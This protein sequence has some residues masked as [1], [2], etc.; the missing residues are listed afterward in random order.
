MNILQHLPESKHGPVLVTLNPPF[1]PDPLKTL[2]RWTYTHPM[3]TAESVSSQPILPSIQ[4]KRHISY[5]GAWT[6]YGF[7]EDGFT[8]AMRLVTAPPFSVKPPFPVRP[9]HRGVENKDMVEET[10]SVVLGAMQMVL[11]GAEP[12]WKWV[13]ILAVVVL[14]LVG[15][16]AEALH[17]DPV[18]NEVER[19]RVCWEGSE[20][21]ESRKRR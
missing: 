12:V 20:S 13:V 18:V 5:A 10:L 19:L 16:L 9:A 3:M 21:E 8:S 17:L 1:P 11:L 7:H 14:G 15:K 6:K 2:G 4:N